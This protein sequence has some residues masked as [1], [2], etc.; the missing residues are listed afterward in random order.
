MSYARCEPTLYL[1]EPK[2]EARGKTAQCYLKRLSSYIM[3]AGYNTR[4]SFFA[5]SAANSVQPVIVDYGEEDAE[6]NAQASQDHV[7]SEAHQIGLATIRMPSPVPG[8]KLNVLP[9]D[10]NR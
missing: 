6:V 9:L 3:L 10:A 7:A 5:D 1:L 2:S 4:V 8:S